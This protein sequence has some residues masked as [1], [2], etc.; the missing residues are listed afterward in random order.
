M[1]KIT[2]DSLLTREYDRTYKNFMEIFE[3]VSKYS[4]ERI[5][6]IYE[7]AKRNCCTVLDLQNGRM[8][9]A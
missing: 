9:Y 3:K 4:A 5:A 6:G 2:E 1:L 8:K 7:A